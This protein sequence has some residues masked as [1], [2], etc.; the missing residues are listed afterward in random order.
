MT[1]AVLKKSECFGVPED[2]EES[3]VFT[4]RDDLIKKKVL[5]FPQ[6]KRVYNPLGSEN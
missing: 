4:V 2:L 1:S 6:R 5:V 3:F